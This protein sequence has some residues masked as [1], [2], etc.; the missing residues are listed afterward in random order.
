MLEDDIYTFRIDAYTPET[1]PM[2]RLA[3]Y[4]AV[5]AEM[6][7]EKSS[8][9]FKELKLGSTKMLSRVEREAVPK[10]RQNITNARS[11]DGRPEAVKAYKKANDML[12]DDNAAA[13]LEL[14]GSNVLDFPA[15][16]HQGLPN[17]ARSIRP[18]RRMATW[19]ASAEKTKPLTP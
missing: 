18:S 5:I 16:T 4:M 12:R 11:G 10:V 7:G 8:V 17:L 14:L 1:I 6:F 13:T 3:E 9:H 2:A 15:G 19:C